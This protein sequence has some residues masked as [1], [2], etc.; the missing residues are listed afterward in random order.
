KLRE[1]LKT[2]EIGIRWIDH[3]RKIVRYLYEFEH[4]VRLSV[5]DQAPTADAWER[6]VARK[7]P[8]V[9]NTQGE[10]ATV[11]NLP[12]TERAKSSVSVPIVAG[13]RALGAIIVENYE[14]EH[15]FSDSEVRLLM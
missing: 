4:G 14:R 15:A 6:L 2:D 8:R 1:V 12:G 9:L 13:E 5:P 11:G 7:G 3:D 10:M